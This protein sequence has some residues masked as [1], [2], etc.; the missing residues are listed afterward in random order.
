[1]ADNPHCNR[2][3]DERGGVYG[4]ETNECT[5]R[6]GNPAH[7][8]ALAEADRVT[9]EVILALPVEEKWRPTK[10]CPTQ[11]PEPHLLGEFPMTC[12]RCHIE[13]DS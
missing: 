11:I 12:Y 6:R 1:M 2:C 7:D 3:G 5:W 8:A 9:A 13:A 4:H 10:P